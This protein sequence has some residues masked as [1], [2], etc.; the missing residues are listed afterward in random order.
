MT[1]SSP[2]SETTHHEVIVISD[3]DEK[4]LH[5][6]AQRK[7]VSSVLYFRIY[8]CFIQERNFPFRIRSENLVL[9]KIVVKQPQ[10]KIVIDDRLIAKRDI[11]PCHK[12]ENIRTVCRSLTP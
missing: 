7:V 1:F 4:P 6:V 10:R 8:K 3:D 5:V 2:R 12:I 9:T 11:R